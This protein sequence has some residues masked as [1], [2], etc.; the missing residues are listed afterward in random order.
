[1]YMYGNTRERQAVNE[2]SGG[3]ILGSAST[4][5]GA[6]ANGWEAGGDQIGAEGDPIHMGASDGAGGGGGYEMKLPSFQ[7]YPG[8]WRK[9]PG[10]QSLSYHDR[11]VWWEIINIMF[12]SEPRGMLTLNGKAMP[13]EAI[14][15]ILGLDNQ[16]LTTT[17][18]TLLTYGV[19][20]RDEV[21]GA[22]CCRRIIRDE[23]LRKT[24][25]NCGKLGGN[26]RLLN[27]IPTTKD[28]VFP[29]PSSSSSSSSSDIRREASPRTQFIPPNLQQVK[30]EA[31]LLGM[32]D[33]DAE[34][35]HDHFSS[36]GWKVGGKT[37][38]VDWLASLRTWK[39]NK[40]KFSNTQQQPEQSSS[41]QPARIAGETAAQYTARLQVYF[42]KICQER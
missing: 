1:M 9:D 19:A 39:R 12:E 3:R 29:T 5:C 17:L 27:Q 2:A 21:T 18:T 20:S 26:P 7:Y 11:G 38:M 13:D 42:D 22:L 25:A 37:R 4:D 24:R 28:K 10:V 16:I 36:N 8:D 33:S 23:N 31:N 30:T 14:A 34:G 15:R 40:G 41:S 6:M 35:F 32:T